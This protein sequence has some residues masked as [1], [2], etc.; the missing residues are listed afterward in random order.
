[1]CLNTGKSYN[2]RH[3]L[4]REMHEDK[5]N[6]QYVVFVEYNLYPIGGILEF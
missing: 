2:E 1:M 5:V 3:F 6:A 4:E